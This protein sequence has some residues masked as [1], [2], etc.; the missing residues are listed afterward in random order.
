MSQLDHGWLVVCLGARP[1]PP[2]PSHAIGPGIAQVPHNA[3]R[4]SRALLPDLCPQ[5]HQ[6]AR[7]KRQKQV[8]R[9]GKKNCISQNWLWEKLPHF[10]SAG[11][12]KG[13]EKQGKNKREV[14][15]GGSPSPG[16]VAKWFSIIWTISSS[17]F[18][19]WHWT[20]STTPSGSQTMN[21]SSTTTSTMSLAPCSSG[22]SH[23]LQLSQ[24]CWV[25][26]NR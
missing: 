21:C 23:L 9:K 5:G 2:N 18:G 22:S 7:G 17:D 19:W 12:G 1:M 14:E 10:R 15:S 11:T 26:V 8:E 4:P 24:S 20:H 13:G 6:P 16:Y 3:S 25:N